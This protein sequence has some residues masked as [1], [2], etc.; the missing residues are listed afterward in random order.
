MTFATA[1]RAMLRQA[2]NIIMVGE[3]R[4]RETAEIAVNAALTGHLVFSTLH[5]NDAPGAVT[6]LVDIGVKPFLVASALRAVVS[7]RLLRRLCGRCARPEAPT[8]SGA[9][10][11]IAG[12]AAGAEGRLRRSVGCP[13]CEGTGYRGRLGI[14]ELL[15]VDDEMQRLIHEGAGIAGLRKRAR[16]LGMSTL[17]EDGLRKAREGLTT[18][19]EVMAATVADAN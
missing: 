7:Q 13:F 3:I 17:R 12:A 6:R 19:E 9:G 11:F 1:L 14:F 8:P 10:P 4:D 15:E 16:E 18:V 2:P 5:T